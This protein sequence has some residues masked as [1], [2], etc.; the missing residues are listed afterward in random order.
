MNEIIERAIDHANKKYGLAL[1]A[2]IAEA[3]ELHV[4]PKELL[5]AV[6]FVE[7]SFNP[8]A[9]SICGALGLMQFMPA[10]AKDMELTC[11]FDARASLLAGAKYLRLLYHVFDENWYFAVMA[12]NCGLGNLR[13]ALDR[14]IDNDENPAEDWGVVK[15]YVPDET[16]SYIDRIA[17]LWTP[18]SSAFEQ[19]SMEA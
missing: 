18:E 4:V 14:A 19:Q 7:S 17:G 2:W 9:V 12:Y 10:T 15:K 1:R 3:A 11:P 8:W 16:K 6:V 5:K 13:K